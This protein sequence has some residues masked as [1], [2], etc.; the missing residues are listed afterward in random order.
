MFPRLP[1]TQHTSGDEQCWVHLSVLS[2]F[3]FFL[4]RSLLTE[5]DGNS[6]RIN[7]RSDFCGEARLV[8]LG[9]RDGGSK[10][11]TEKNQTPPGLRF[12]ILT[13]GI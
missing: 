5:V 13:D 10:R 6:S 11:Y 12:N 7:R 9:W 1:A 8:A 2:A 3:L 4:L